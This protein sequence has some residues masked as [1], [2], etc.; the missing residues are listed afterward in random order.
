MTREEAI[1]TIQM[2]KAEV[3][4]SYPMDYQV[5]F[6]MA[7][8]ALEQQPCEDA[9]SR[10][11]VMDLLQNESEEIYITSNGRTKICVAEIDVEDL[12]ALPTVSCSEKPNRS[13]EWIRVDDTKLKCSECEVIHFI[14]QYPQGQIKFCP[15]CGA[16][17]QVVGNPDR[18][19]GGAE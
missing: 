7:I 19:N 2:A 10:Q 8:N 12:K 4:W 11:A 9:I 17:M 13:G 5:A 16:R 3:E 18:L 6:D 1:K 15:N 14:A